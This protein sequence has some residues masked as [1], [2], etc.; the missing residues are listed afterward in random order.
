MGHA[1]AL[2]LEK[3]D[4]ASRKEKLLKSAGVVMT[5]HPA[6]FGGIMKNLLDTRKSLYSAVRPSAFQ[7]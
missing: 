3:P 2:A 4:H 5:D 1:G 6:K 7:P